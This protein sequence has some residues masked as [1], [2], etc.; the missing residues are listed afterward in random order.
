MDTM[1]APKSDQQNYDDFAAEPR[2]ITIT[3]VE[4]ADSKE[5]PV[6]I[7]F[8]TDGGRPYKPNLTMR[9][10][11]RA[12]WGRYASQYVGRRMTLWGDPTAPWGGKEV[13]G[14]RISHMDGIDAPKKLKVTKKRGVKDTITIQPLA[15]ATT[16][17]P[18]HTSNAHKQDVPKAGTSTSLADEATARAQNEPESM[19]HWWNSDETKQRRAELYKSD[20]D[21]AAQLKSIV[22]RVI[23]EN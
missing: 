5:Q 11:I 12:I 23:A 8:D 2:T 15:S 21:A 10:V 14:I 13:G 1:I 20:P 16:N 19:S 6:L 9:R 4:A 17:K 22:E 18:E 3:R 7:Y